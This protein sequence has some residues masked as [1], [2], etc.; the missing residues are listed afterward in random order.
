MPFFLSH[1]SFPGGMSGQ[2]DESYKYCV[3]FHYALS[4]VSIPQERL[5]SLDVAQLLPMYTVCEC[6]VVLVKSDVSLRASTCVFSVI[7]VSSF[8]CAYVL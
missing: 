3:Y 2:M 7:A 4:T 5:P 6:V 1:E 8:H